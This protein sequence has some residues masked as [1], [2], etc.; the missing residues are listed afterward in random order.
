VR[1]ENQIVKMRTDDVVAE[2]LGDEVVVYDVRTQE[3]HL[4]SGSTAKLWRCAEGVAVQQ[5]PVLMGG[6]AGGIQEVWEAI[7]LMQAK[8]LLAE[9]IE[10]PASDTPGLSRRQ[11]LKRMG[12][13][14]VALPAIT[15]LLSQQPAAAACGRT[16][17]QTCSNLGQTGGSANG[18]CCSGRTCLA[19]TGGPVCCALSGES[20][21]AA[22]PCCAGSGVCGTVV[23]GRCP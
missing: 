7:E 23:A 8:G 3:A 16:A 19:G 2:D 17:G 4:L 1:L 15:T 11:I 22:T 12:I 20:C 6:P 10:V 14:A 9:R 5:L 18:D 13:A 21:S